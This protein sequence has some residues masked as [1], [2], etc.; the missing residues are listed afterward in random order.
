MA[1]VE[2]SWTRL[3][4]VPRDPDLGT[5]LRAEV[6]DPLWLLSRQLQFRELRGE[7]AGSPVRVTLQG[8]AS[9]LTRYH[10]GPPD[11]TPGHPSVGR[12]PLEA[13]VEAEPLVEDPLRV[14]AAAGLHFLRLLTAEGVASYADVYRR[15]YP[16]TSTDPSPAARR[17]LAVLAGRAPDG[18]TLQQDLAAAAPALPAEPAVAP[19]DT[20][21]VRRAASSLLAW[22]Q[23][24][25][26][27]DA[28]PAWVPP[29]F[30]YQFTVAGPSDAGEVVLTATEYEQG[31]LDWNS[32]DLAP[33]GST[34][35]AAADQGASSD[36]GRTG[37]PSPV[38]YRG[39]PTARF[40]EFED[41][42]VDFGDLGAAP[43]ELAKLLLIEFATV[44]GNDHFIVPVDVDVGSICRVQRLT[45]ID[46]FGRET[47][48]PHVAEADA[49]RPGTF[50]L[51]ELGTGGIRSS[52]F[53]LPPV[54]AQ[55][56][57][58]QPIEEVHLLRD[59][60][61]NL[62]WAVEATATRSD[63]FPVDRA[64]AWRAEQSR[65]PPVPA[66]GDP[67]W[68]YRLRTTVPEH[69]FPLVPVSDRPGVNHLELG[70]LAG[71][72]GQPGTPPWG[73]ILGG[74]GTA[75]VP[76]EEAARSGARIT[77]A[78]QY[79]RWVDGRQHAWIG[80]RRRS[81]APEGDSGLRFDTIEPTSEPPRS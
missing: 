40:W 63:G 50:R 51:F 59:E 44:Y 14:A 81:G 28:A 67:A 11:G 58:A 38:V 1:T 39:M 23:A 72:D 9:R 5:G 34:L 15:R 54:L 4:P 10:P 64:G 65:E 32:F 77:R 56:L 48:I 46:T 61:A 16:L 19:A 22:Y 33:A 7:D 73:R 26:P 17:F 6:H 57:D 31:R 76:E 36:L 47:A 13:V 18:A 60:G 71:L 25:D 41:A 3:E 45:V 27:P 2:P 29:R 80:R 8:Q 79:A 49:N 74:L 37:L 20:P 42:A 75:A 62:A 24:L 69:W 52:L 12:R 30:E 35:G 68:R 53:L 70:T 66:G 43:E 78:W 55:S 21:A